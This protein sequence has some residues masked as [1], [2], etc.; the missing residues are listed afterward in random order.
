MALW[1]KVFSAKPDDLS[2]VPETLTE[3]GNDFH[4]A[5][6][7]FHMGSVAAPPQHKKKQNKIK[8]N[9]T[10]FLALKRQCGKGSGRKQETESGELRNR[11]RIRLTTIL[12][13]NRLKTDRN[14][15]PKSSPCRNTKTEIILGG[16]NLVIDFGNA[17]SNLCANKVIR[18]KLK[19]ADT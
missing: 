3:E 7:D 17:R 6:P 10:Q 9:L 1:V 15:S 5:S 13:E 11:E 19:E 8:K 14:N 12:S 4:K 18:I 2:L 16:R